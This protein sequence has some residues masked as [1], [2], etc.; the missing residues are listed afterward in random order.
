[1]STARPIII[2]GIVYSGETHEQAFARWDRERAHL[3]EEAAEEARLAAWK[4][5][6]WW[7]DPAQPG[8]SSPADV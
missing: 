1:M 6:G 4:A 3:E 5:R 2:P 8:A 7:E